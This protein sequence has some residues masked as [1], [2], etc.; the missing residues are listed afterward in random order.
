MIAEV[1]L[2]ISP[3]VHIFPSFT[4]GAFLIPYLLFLAFGG[5]PIFFL[6][7]CVGQFTQS[8]PVH[9]WTKLCPLLRGRGVRFSNQYTSQVLYF[10]KHPLIFP[11]FQNDERQPKLETGVERPEK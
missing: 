8:E 9:A 7:Q 11:H 3:N 5:V 6:E 1:D 4:L 2:K 10:F